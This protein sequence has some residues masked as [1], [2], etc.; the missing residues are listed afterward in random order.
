MMLTS[1]F[2]DKN[3]LREIIAEA[4]SR[5]QGQMMSAGHSVAVNRALSYF[6]PSAVLNEKLS[7]VEF[8]KQIEKWEADFEQYADVLTEKLKSLAKQIFRVENLMVDLVAEEKAYRDLLPC[9]EALKEKMYTDPIKKSGY[10][11]VP[12]K[13]TEGLKSASQVQYVASAGNFRNRGFGYT[14]VLKVLKVMMGYDYLWNQ[15][16]VKGGAYGCMCNFGKSGDCYF[17]SYRDPNLKNTLEVYGKAADYI[18]NFEVDERA[19]TQYIIGAISDLDMPMNPAAKGL[20][21][22]SGYLTGVTD[23]MLQKERY[24]IINAD[25][26]AL[27]DCAKLIRAFVEDACICVVG[28]AEKIEKDK[29]LFDVIRPL[30]QN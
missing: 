5:M 9:I 23:E 22:L 19:M 15:V 17:V 2:S 4:K 7:G 16:R 11:P 27:R 13:E 12:E 8:Y 3:R 21:S 29:D 28:N 6:S 18:E 10:V 26:A 14:G 25:G 20:F 30:F 1:D 24:E